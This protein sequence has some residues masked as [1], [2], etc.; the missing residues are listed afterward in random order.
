M[1]EE[2]S[3]LVPSERRLERMYEVAADSS[4]V[5]I[6]D[7]RRRRCISAIRSILIQRLELASCSTSCLWNWDW[8]TDFR[9]VG[10]LSPE[11]SQRRRYR[12]R[13]ARAIKSHS[14]WVSWRLLKVRGH[15][16]SKKSI[17]IF[18]RKVGLTVIELSE[19]IAIDCIEYNEELKKP[20]VSACILPDESPFACLLTARSWVWPKAP[21][22]T[23]RALA[24]HLWSL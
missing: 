20:G 22:S 11:A 23:P 13:R 1:V 7:S 8:T 6:G 16:G 24:F 10:Y 15:S 9:P 18:V 4:V 17:P 2:Y 21:Q 19:M 14:T 3:S 12:P 5:G